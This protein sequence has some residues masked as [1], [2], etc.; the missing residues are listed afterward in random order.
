MSGVIRATLHKKIVQLIVRLIT[1]KNSRQL[2][3][4]DADYMVPHHCRNLLERKFLKIAAD[5]STISASLRLLLFKYRLLNT[6]FLV[7]KISEIDQARKN[8]RTIL[9]CLPTFLAARVASARS[10]GNGH[11]DCHYQVARK[12]HTKPTLRSNEAPVVPNRFAQPSQT[13]SLPPRA[14][15]ETSDVRPRR[16][17]CGKL[18]GS[19]WIGFTGL[20]LAV[21]EAGTNFRF[22]RSLLRHGFPKSVLT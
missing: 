15:Q 6:R 3:R 5:A 21:E 20:L 2:Y 10:I 11:G 14:N 17:S 9:L 19:I 7:Y 4:F 1:K 13:N 16:S 18:S 8:K 22:E 12:N